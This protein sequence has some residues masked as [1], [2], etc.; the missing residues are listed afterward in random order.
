MIVIKRDGSKEEFNRAKIKSAIVGAFQSV[1][2]LD[3]EKMWLP[4]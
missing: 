2:S 3:E 4:T 1:S